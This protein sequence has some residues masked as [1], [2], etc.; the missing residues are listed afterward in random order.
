MMTSKTNKAMQ[1]AAIVLE[2][3]HMMRFRYVTTHK[4]HISNITGNI[5]FSIPQVQYKTEELIRIPKQS[6]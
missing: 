6:D 4:Q 2:S 5:I 3:P 1:C